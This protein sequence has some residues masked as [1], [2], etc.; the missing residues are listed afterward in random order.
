MKAKTYLLWSQCSFSK[1]NSRESH[2]RPVRECPEAAPLYQTVLA[3]GSEPCLMALH[4]TVCRSSEQCFA[5]PQ[6]RTIKTR[7]FHQ[8][9]GWIQHKIHAYFWM[10][11]VYPPEC[12]GI[13]QSIPR[14]DPRARIGINL[15]PSPMHARNVHFVLSLTTWLV[16]HQFHCQFDDFFETCKHLPQ[17]AGILSALQR[18]AGLKRDAINPSL[19]TGKRLLTRPTFNQSKHPSYVWQA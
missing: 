9:L 7:T 10:P 1:W 16:S 13:W 14:W 5:N 11:C 17:D 19:M 12:S 2:Q 18:L 3:S 6:G 4:L 15:G 8:N